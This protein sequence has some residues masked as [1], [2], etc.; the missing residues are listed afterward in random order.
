MINFTSVAHPDL[1]QSQLED[2]KKYIELL[3]ARHVNQINEI[4]MSHKTQIS[5][6]ETQVSSKDSKARSWLLIHISTV[7]RSYLLTPY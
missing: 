5:N 4:K 7:Y 1:F 3:H 6:L 2:K